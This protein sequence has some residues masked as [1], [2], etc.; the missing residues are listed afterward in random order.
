MIDGRSEYAMPMLWSLPSKMH[1][2]SLRQQKNNAVHNEFVVERLLYLQ[3]YLPCINLHVPDIFH[4]N[5]LSDCVK[6]QL[7]KDYKIL[8]FFDR[9]PMKIYEPLR[10]TICL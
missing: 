1:V 4:S 6:K 3:C 7:V 2:G 9:L 5:Q 8:Y 10:P